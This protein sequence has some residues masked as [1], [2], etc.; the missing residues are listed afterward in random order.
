M[1]AHLFLL[2]RRSSAEP[3]TGCLWDARGFRAGRL[4]LT[5]YEGKSERRR[6]ELS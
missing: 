3:Q 2:A 6:F 5:D 4:R 1:G